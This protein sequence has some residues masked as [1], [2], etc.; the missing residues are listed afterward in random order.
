MFSGIAATYQRAD[1]NLTTMTCQARAQCPPCYSPCQATYHYRRLCDCGD[2]GDSSDDDGIGDECAN[3]E[4]SITAADD[5]VECVDGGG[6]SDDDGIDAVK[7][8]VMIVGIR[9]VVLRMM[10]VMLR[11]W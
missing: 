6:N 2:G 8:M 10:M 4:W 9:M 5:I 11:W 1:V 3:G 7:M